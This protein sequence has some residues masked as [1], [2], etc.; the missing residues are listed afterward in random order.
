MFT[1][2]SFLLLVRHSSRA[3]FLPVALVLGARGLTMTAALTSVSPQKRLKLCIVG[4]VHG[5]WNE[6]DVSALRAISPNLACFVGDFGNEAVDIVASIA[7]SSD[8]RFPVVSVLGNHDAW[9]VL[10]AWSREVKADCDAK[11]IRRK[12]SS[13]TL[14]VEGSQESTQ[15]TAAGTAASPL[16]DR[17][18]K[19]LN[20]LSAS[21]VSFSRRD[22]EALGLSVIGGRPFSAGGPTFHPRPFYEHHYNVGSFEEAA[23]RVVRA[24]EEAPP[25][26][27]LIFLAHNGPSG[28]GE[29]PESPCGKDWGKAPGGD[30]GDRDLEEAVAA[31]AG[32][33]RQRHLPLVLYGHMHRRLRCGGERA[34]VFDGKY[35]ELYVNAA[36]VPRWRPH[37][38]SVGLESKGLG[39]D[40]MSSSTETGQREV[41]QTLQ[42]GSCDGGWITERHFTIVELESAHTCSSGHDPASQRSNGGGE[43]WEVVRVTGTWALPN[44]LVTEE[45]LLWVKSCKSDRAWQDAE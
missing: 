34:C 9:N 4:D 31:V 37:L 33:P 1:R 38:T 20:L 44:G 14:N 18:R 25:T 13:W 43:R 36:M 24:S 16:Y 11:A 7:T 19:Q 15:S 39:A 5:Q 21:D 29:S 45:E 8:G 6:H 35:G 27:S 40:A 32:P 22:F 30:W 28:L 23:A 41:G 10:K 2:L 42:E 26:N 3:Y 17:L 12:H